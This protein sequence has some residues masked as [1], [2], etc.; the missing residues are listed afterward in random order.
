MGLL[1][2][3]I[4]FCLAFRITPRGDWGYAQIPT[5]RDSLVELSIV[6]DTTKSLDRAMSPKRSSHLKHIPM[7]HPSVLESMEAKLK[8]WRPSPPEEGSSAPAA[9]ASVPDGTQAFCKSAAKPP[10]PSTF[11]RSDAPVVRNVRRGSVSEA[12]SSLHSAGET[13][14]V[15]DLFRYRTAMSSY[16]S[17]T[18]LIS[19]WHR[20]HHE[21]FDTTT[22]PPRSFQSLSAAS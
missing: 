2:C 11:T 9:A 1:V 22:M 16:A 12:I 17:R 7:Q 18:S 3:F 14:L 10:T 21:A 4:G 8:R 5:R 15:N 13:A 20:F 19:T 6:N